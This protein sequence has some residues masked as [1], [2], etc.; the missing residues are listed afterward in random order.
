MAK[1]AIGALVAS[2]ALPAAL[3]AQ[4]VPEVGAPP[5]PRQP[6]M[7]QPMPTGDPE[8]AYGATVP[9]AWRAPQYYIADYDRYDL[10]RPARGF[11][12]SHYRGAYVLTDRWGRIYDWRENDFVN[13]RYDD[14]GR[15][16][17]HRDFDR[18]ASEIDTRPHWET[19]GPGSGE[20][21]YDTIT[22][23]TTRICTPVVARAASYSPV[24]T[25]R[26]VHPLKHIPTAN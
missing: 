1:V 11:G 25:R 12:W 17:R 14:R 22:T 9:P 19:A 3:A 26:R 8:P 20:I 15:H 24:N 21:P 10:R 5:V 13:G 2:F 6:A 18:D 23:T 7:T 16:H 4:P